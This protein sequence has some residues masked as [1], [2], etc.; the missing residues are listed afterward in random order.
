MVIGL[1]GKYCAGKN[2]AAAVLESK[3]WR[4]IDVDKLGHQALKAQ[5]GLIKEAFG[6]AVI[7]NEGGIESVNRKALGKIV[8]SSAEQLQRLEQISHPWMVTETARLITQY[9][10][11]GAE[12]VIINAAVL[13]RMKLDSLCGAV[14]WIEAPLLTRIR[15]ALKRDN[16]GIFQI[17]KRI[18]TQRQLKPKPSAES[19]DTYRVGNNSDSDAL[20]RNLESVLEQIEQKER[21]GR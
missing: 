6:D 2:Q 7:I 11:E 21:N 9:Q 13:Y 1:T 17:F 12:H 3:G 19:V 20:H 18:Y 5:T 15:R 16:A 14:I 4:S 10:A 8:F